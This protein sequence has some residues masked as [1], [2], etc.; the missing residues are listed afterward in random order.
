MQQRRDSETK[1]DMALDSEER[2]K[3]AR[4]SE[5]GGLHDLRDRLVRIEVHTHNILQQ[6]KDQAKDREIM[7]ERQA[8]HSTRLQAVETKAA[9]HDKILT[10]VNTVILTAVLAAILFA[11]GISRGGVL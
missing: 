6:L 1:K 8:S 5:D 11:A 9:R 4:R 10:W 2:R 3:E 7:K